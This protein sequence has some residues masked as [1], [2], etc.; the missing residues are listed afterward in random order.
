MTSSS[1]TR[2]DLAPEV[3]APLLFVGYGL[4]VPEKNY[5]DFAGLDLKGKV[6]VILSGSPAE[7]PGSLASH[8]QT[9]CRT[10]EGAAGGRSR[11]RNQHS[12]SCLDGCAVVAHRR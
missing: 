6:V 12:E 11:G 9:R 7:I 3:E 1:R 4:K 8:Y 5:D 2:I 10:M